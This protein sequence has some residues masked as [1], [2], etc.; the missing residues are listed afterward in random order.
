MKRINVGLIG[1]GRI[2]P[3]H[4]YGYKMLQ[5]KGVDVR[6]KALCARKME[7]A[8]R[9]RS[10][11]KS[12]L[13]WRSVGPPGDPL[14]VPPIFVYDFQRDVD[15]EPYT[16]YREM[17]KKADVDAVDIY[18]SHFA[19]H[20]ISIAASKSGK[21][22]M[23]EKPMAITVKAGWKMIETA[24]KAGKVLAV[25]EDSHWGDMEKWVIDEGY[26]GNV[27]LLTFADMGGYWSPSQIVAN[28]GWRHRKLEAGGGAAIDFGVH[29]F[30]SMQ[31]VGEID[32][33]SAIAK[34]FE[35]ERITQENGNVTEK[36]NVTADDSYF[37]LARYKNGAVGFTAFS[38]ALHGEPSSLVNGIY[39]SKGCI[40]GDEVILDDGR[41]V[42]VRD[43]F[44]KESLAEDKE[45]LFPMG[46]TDSFALETY[47][48]LKA[49]EEG[50][51]PQVS[52][53][54]G[55]RDLACGYAVLESSYLNRPVKIS[56]VESGAIE[57]YQREINKHY[58]L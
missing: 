13:P 49:I 26:I 41:R 4:L 53:R 14:N 18:T 2:M 54:A 17:L 24:E 21:H 45:K 57:G 43:L 32:E 25:A 33:I 42:K 1:C 55:L 31:K 35:K 58:K 28:T 5:E 37:C 29:V 38:Y 39:G 20:T 47:D 7:D 12:S 46:I 34:V 30:H 3:A 11:E 9:Y 23:V 40:K 56:D 51:K 22:V 44:E 16:D 10:R 8:L 6:I 36:V 27:Q 48:W 15:V 50:R 52:G 19:H